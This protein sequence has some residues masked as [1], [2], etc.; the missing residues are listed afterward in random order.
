MT[1]NEITLLLLGESG[2]GKSTFINA[3]VNYMTYETMAEAKD[4]PHC[5]IP[6]SFTVSDEETYELKSIQMCPQDDDTNENTTDPTKSATQNPRCYKFT[7]GNIAL[8]II[9][10]PGIADTEGIER[11]IKI[12][13][14]F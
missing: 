1:K 14:I 9:D 12:W 11:I 8:N 2:V 6:V 4:Q 7:D 10:T 5:L 3:F 13:K